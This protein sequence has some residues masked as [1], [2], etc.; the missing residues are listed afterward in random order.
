MRRRS[1]TIDRI[2]LLGGGWKA[3]WEWPDVEVSG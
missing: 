2:G 1:G 3:G